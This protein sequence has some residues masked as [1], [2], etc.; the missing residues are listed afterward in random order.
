MSGNGVADGPVDQQVGVT[1]NGR[2][3]VG[4]HVQ[5]QAEMSFLLRAVN[6][7]SHGAQQD[8]LDE[9]FVRPPGNFLDQSAVILG[10]GLVAAAQA[11]T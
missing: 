6:G 7:L 3:E 4:V 9:V 10:F 1:A 11:E 5:R 2:G 8:G